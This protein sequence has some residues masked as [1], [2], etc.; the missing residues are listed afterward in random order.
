[1]GTPLKKANLSLQFC[2]INNIHITNSKYVLSPS[3]PGAEFNLTT[4]MEKTWRHPI[5]NIN[6]TQ[7]VVS[8]VTR[9]TNRTTFW[10]LFKSMCYTALDLYHSLYQPG[11]EFN[12][13]TF[14]E[15]TW[16]HPIQN[17]NHTQSV[18]SSVTR[19]TNRTTFWL[20]F[21]SMCYTALDLY[22]NLPVHS[23]SLAP[24]SIFRIIK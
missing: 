17:I 18:V 2:C 4:F 16:R 1:M 5:Q 22:H 19:K 7:S 12:L 20:L 6:H 13:T 23:L 9:K 14:M 15:K 10:L 8:S 3:Q 24:K 11:A 21:K